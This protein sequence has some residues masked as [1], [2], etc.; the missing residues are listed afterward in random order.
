MI[1]MYEPSSEAAARDISVPV[2]LAAAKP[3]PA[4]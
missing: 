3:V 4:G 1:K 2:L